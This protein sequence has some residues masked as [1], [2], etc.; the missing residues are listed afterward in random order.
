MISL[1][2]TIRGQPTNWE[3]DYEVTYKWTSHFVHGTVVAVDTHALEP[4]TAFTVGG[5]EQ[6]TEKGGM[7][8]FNSAMYVF[9][10]TVLVFRGLKYEVPKELLEH[11]DVVIKQLA[12]R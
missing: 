9:K 3:F 11:F 5:R 12:K 2:S 6:K 10:S 1:K 7:A 4:G 8:I